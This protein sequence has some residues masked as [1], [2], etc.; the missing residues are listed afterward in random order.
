MIDGGK[1]QEKKY[2]NTQYYKKQFSPEP[3]QGHDPQLMNSMGQILGTNAPLPTSIISS[4]HPSTFSIH[5][6]IF[7]ASIHPYITFP[8]T[9]RGL[10]IL[11]VAVLAMA[12]VFV[13][14]VCWSSV[15]VN[16]EA[17]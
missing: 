4:I 2:S 17:A 15:Q 13:R 7:P 10:C 9:V 12:D 1:V 14:R 8:Q 3:T 6:L 5:P 11:P 16:R